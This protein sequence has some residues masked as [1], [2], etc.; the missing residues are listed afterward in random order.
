M[1][2]LTFSTIVLKFNN[3]LEH[4]YSF[5]TEITLSGVG[6]SVV[7]CRRKENNDSVCYMVSKNSTTRS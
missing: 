7:L 5:F 2:Y 1:I 6:W 3:F 4:F